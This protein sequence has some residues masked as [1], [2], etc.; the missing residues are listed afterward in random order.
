MRANHKESDLVG[1]KC[2]QQIPE[3]GDHVL[4]AWSC[5]VATTIGMVSR[6]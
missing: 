3:I 5:S 4:P 6:V 2:G 1:D